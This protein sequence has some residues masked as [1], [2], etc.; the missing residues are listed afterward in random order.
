[1]KLVIIEGLD[2]TGKTTVIHELMQ[3]YNNV[4]YIHA[5]KPEIDDPVLCALHQQEVF[6]KMVSNIQEVFCNVPST[7]LII[8]DR[9]WIGEYVYGCMYRGNGDTFVENMIADCYNRIA[10]AN[11]LRDAPVDTLDCTTIL[12]T[13]RTPEFCLKNEDDQSLSARDVK[14]ISIERDRFEKIMSSSVIRGK[15]KIITVED[16]N[17]EFLPK[18]HIL[19]LTINAIENDNN[20]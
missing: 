15:K 19:N 18:E 17:G 1:M 12:Y 20:E 11:R 2:N 9:S 7:D 6:T 13:V 10:N 14:K 16:E 3:R 8:L 5:T 4:H